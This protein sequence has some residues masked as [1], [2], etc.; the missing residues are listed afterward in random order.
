MHHLLNKMSLWFKPCSKCPNLWGIVLQVVYDKKACMRR[1]G[2]LEI[3]LVH[4]HGNWTRPDTMWVFSLTLPIKLNNCGQTSIQLFAYWV[5]G[6]ELSIFNID[7]LHENIRNNNVASHVTCCRYDKWDFIG[8]QQSVHKLDF[9][10]LC[11]I[12]TSSICE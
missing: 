3:M 12:L 10:L 1:A 6:T 5:P 9:F 8:E 2:I 4:K 7:S 11:I